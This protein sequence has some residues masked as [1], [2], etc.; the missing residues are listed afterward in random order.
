MKS[1][2]ELEIDAPQARTAELYA[3]PQNCPRW[4]DDLEKYEPISGQPGM[5]A[6]TFRMVPKKGD[7]V[8]V[9]TVVARNL[10][11][12]VRMNLEAANV[13]VTVKATFA[14]LSAETTRLTSEEDFHF[15]GFFNRVFGFLAHFSIKKAHRN[16]IEAFKR[17]AEAHR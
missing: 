15:K 7:M 5:P 17:F 11:D 10:P 3:D 8:F 2:I 14:A 1:V 16:H 13:R 9:A 12:E 6:S 4:M